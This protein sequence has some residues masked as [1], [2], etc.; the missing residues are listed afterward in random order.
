[1]QILY[2]FVLVFITISVYVWTAILEGREVSNPGDEY[3]IISVTD[4]LNNN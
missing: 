4:G 1:M 3:E 2:A